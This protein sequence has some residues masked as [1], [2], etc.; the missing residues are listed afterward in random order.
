MS[1]DID[2]R[3]CIEKILPENQLEYERIHSGE[4]SE[5]DKKT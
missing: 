4:H 2:I 3:A 1:T 5:S